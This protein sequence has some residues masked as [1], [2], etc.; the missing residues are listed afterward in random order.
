MSPRI[1]ELRLARWLGPWTLET[2]WP[3]HTRRS[4][5]TIAGPMERIDARIYRPSRGAPMASVLL[6]PGLHYLGPDDPRLDR[7]ARVLAEAG[8]LVFAPF[9]PDSLRLVVRPQ[10]IDDARAAF[11]ALLRL[12]D[13]PSGKPGIVSIS[14]GSLPAL[15]ITASDLGD[16]VGQ[17]VTFGGYADFGS[18]VRFALRGGVALDNS[19]AN[20][21]HDP[22]NRPVVFMNLLDHF[23]DLP[24]DV[25]RVMAHWRRYVWATWGRQEMKQGRFREVA[26]RMEGDLAG[27]ALR[28]YRQGCGTAPGGDER[29][30]RALQRGKTGLAWLDSD[31]PA[32]QTRC[33]VTVVHGRDDDVI[34]YEQSEQLA[35]LIPGDPSVHLTGLYAHSGKPRLRDLLQMLPAAGG[36][37][38]SMLQIVRAFAALGEG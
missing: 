18:S 16:E 38:W 29:C 15:H 9:L 26:A 12:T 20:R 5:V 33:P 1:A 7:F 31:V 13:R 34:P 8:K 10:V 37:L 22:L 24:P 28:L 21:P 30:E 3:R 35:D 11:E 2:E 23:E 25:D 27:D 4:A 32:K 6:L 19:P 36:E 17:L 14:F